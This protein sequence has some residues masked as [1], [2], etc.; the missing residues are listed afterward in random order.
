MTESFQSWIFSNCC[1]ESKYHTKINVEKEMRV[2]VIP[3]L[4][5]MSRD[6]QVNGRYVC[7]KLL[8]H[9]LIKLFGPVNN[10]WNLLINT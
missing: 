10:K 1:D 6:Q 7:P 9:M 4:E 3:R 5:K 2:V 8:G